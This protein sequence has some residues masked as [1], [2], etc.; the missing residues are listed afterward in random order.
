MAGVGAIPVF[1]TLQ[2]V[3]FNPAITAFASVGPL[4]RAS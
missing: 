1:M 2:P 3:A 4:V